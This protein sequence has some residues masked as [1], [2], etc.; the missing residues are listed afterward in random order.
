ME[1]LCCSVFGR[2]HGGQ[3]HRAYHAGAFNR[4]ALLVL[5]FS[6]AAPP[7]RTLQ[8]LLFTG[9]RRPRC[10][11]PRTLLQVSPGE[12]AAQFR[13][14]AQSFQRPQRKLEEKDVDLRFAR[15]SGPGGQNVNK[16]ETKVEARFDVNAASFLPDWVRANLQKQQAKNIN[17]D[18]MLTV[19]CQEQRTQIANRKLVMEKL[20]DM[21]D[22]AAYIPPPVDPA[23]AER[24]ERIRRAAATRRKEDEKLKKRYKESRKGGGASDYY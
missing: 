19:T 17:R 18:G 12:A 24:L 14:Q 7:D 23:K 11:I 20:Q 13:A 16:V 5:C 1:S 10:G 3:S 15:S 8:L 4:L 21:I 22:E 2:G 6:Q 9:G